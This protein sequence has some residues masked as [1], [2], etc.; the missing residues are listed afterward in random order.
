MKLRYRIWAGVS[1]LLLASVW[2]LRA[3]QGSSASTDGQPDLLFQRNLRFPRAFRRA[4]ENPHEGQVFLEAPT[5]AAGTLPMSIAVGDFNHDGKIDM[6]VIDGGLE[7]FLG[8]GDGTFLAPVNY[9]TGGISPD[10]VAVGDFNG[11]GNLDLSITNFCGNDPTC[12]SVGSLSILLGKGDGTFRQIKVYTVGTNPD[13]VAVADF[14]E[15]GKLIWWSPT[16][17]SMLVTT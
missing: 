2:S 4:S 10:A 3:G 6:A 16:A 1:L 17:F 15:M 12:E 9:R 13:A 7:I 8:K 5:L 14:N 11:D